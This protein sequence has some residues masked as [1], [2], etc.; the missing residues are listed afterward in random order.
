MEGAHVEMF[1][2][3]VAVHRHADRQPFPDQ[4]IQ[5]IAD[6]R[7]GFT[8][9]DG[10][11]RRA[12]Q[13][14]PTLESSRPRSVSLPIVSVL[15]ILLTT[16]PAALGGKAG[17]IYTVRRSEQ[18]E[19]ST[20]SR[21]GEDRHDWFLERFS[22]LGREGEAMTVGACAKIQHPAGS[23]DVGLEGSNVVPVR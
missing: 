7:L 14:M 20:L 1:H 21:P 19:N 18:G 22:D 12:D 9:F 11:L 4:H 6:G 16:A 3:L 17:P 5:V 8:Q 23:I 13:F 10:E 2:A 15:G